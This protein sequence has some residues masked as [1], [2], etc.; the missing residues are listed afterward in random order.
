MRSFPKPIVVIS[1]CLEFEACRYNG[2]RLSDRFVQKLTPFVKFVPVCPEVE[3]GLGTPR[4]AIR[5]SKQGERI[6]LHQP[7]TGRDVTEDMTRFAA[8]WLSGVTEVDGFI[9][10]RKSPSCGVKSV[11]LHHSVGNNMTIGH[12]ESGLFG[13]AVVERFD[14]KAIEDEGRLNDIQI[15]HHWLTRLYA[16]AAFREFKKKPSAAKL[17]EFHSANKLL[18]MAYNQAKM[19]AMGK[20]VA[21]LK[22]KPIGELF[23]EY[24][25]LLEGALARQ[26]RVKQNINV[27]HHA[28]GYFKKDLTAKEK[29]Q[30]L[31]TVESYREELVPLST[32]LVVIRTWEAKYEK[33]Y[34]AG[35][36]FFEPYP[37]ALTQVP[38]M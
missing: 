10:K 9:L 28:F 8:Q 22:A 5:L 32:V 34:L 2:A 25:S 18:L 11:K 24:E 29:A 12:K 35:Q 36:T 14:G 38:V 23:D 33:P 17:V 26:A 20:L 19:R 13:A 16:L 37:E 30:F 7:A 6:V 4:P 31:N 27:I 3:I 1:K 21:A 15:R